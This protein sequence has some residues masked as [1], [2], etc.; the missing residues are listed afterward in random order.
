[1]NSP[2]P[3]TTPLKL[4]YANIAVITGSQCAILTTDG[5]IL[6]Y[7]LS[8]RNT[9]PNTLT[10]YPVIACH[11]P[12]TAKKLELPHIP[13]FDVLELFAF[14][15]PATFITPTFKGLADYCNISISE[16]IDDAPYTMLEIVQTLLKNLSIIP[17]KDKPLLLSIANAMSRQDQGWAWGSFVIEALGGTYDPALPTNPK[18]DMN[19]FDGMPEWAEEAP[20]PQHSYQPVSGEEARNHLQ[21]LLNRRH[22]SGQASQSRAQQQ[23]Y[24]TRV[25]DTLIA[26]HDE[27]APNLL[28][29]QAGTGIGKTFGYL[30]PAQLWAEKNEGRVTISTYTKNLQRQIEQDLHTLY[31][32]PEE[33][34]RKAITQKGRENYLCLLNLDELIA[35]AATAR[36]PRMIVAAGLMARWA[37]VTKDGDMSGN[38]FPGWLTNLLGKQYTLGLTDRRGEC[39][40]AACA[41]YHRC[42]IE[43]MNR[44]AKRA[45]ILISNHA[46]TMIRA[47]TDHSEAAS[48]FIIFD[49]A[50]HLFHAADS[51]FGANLTGLETADLRRWLIGPEEEGRQARIGTIRGRGLRKRLEGLIGEDS[52]AFNDIGKILLAAKQVLPAPGWR[53]RVFGDNPVG[54]T[55]EFLFHLARH[56]AL[57]SKE[58]QSPYS[59]ECDIHPTNDQLI[60]AATKAKQGFKSLRIPLADLMENLKAM[61]EDQ[62]EDIDQDTLARMESL[63]ASIERRSTTMLAAWMGMMDC[64]ID[65]VR[66]EKMVDWFEIARIE[67]KNFDCGY[68]RR[69]KNPMEPLGEVIRPASQGLVL[70][71]AT[72]KAQSGLGEDGW[73]STFDQLGTP[74]L[75]TLAPETIDLPSP[76]QYGEQSRIFIV[77]DVDKQNGIAVANAYKALFEATN[78]G[79]LGLFTSINRLKQVYQS[80]HESLERRSIPLY[81]QHHDN[82][83]IGTLTDMFREDDNACLL[84][85]DAVRDGIN[86]SGQ[87]LRCMVFDRMPWPRPTILHRE[88][89]KIFGGRQYDEN[90]TRL[91]LKQAY[92]RLIR[93]E[94]DKGVFVILDNAMPTRLSD[95]FPQ[96]VSI[97][98]LSLKDTIRNIKEFL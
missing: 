31:P 12:W 15:H 47:A 57:R 38:S 13:V 69:Y 89:K 27:D 36:D 63:I 35:R 52:P 71:S 78:G 92:G 87:S 56:V 97:E 44:K 5:E 77:T 65:Q 46:L 96:D 29:A 54:A 4:P 1:M 49:E 21:T 34:K 45:K 80:I 73:Q 42:F 41:H 25:A 68:L 72:L 60:E 88:R 90:E 58:P 11:A 82:I 9:L 86:V 95:A 8:D 64:L 26:K 22:H 28:I 39:I 59:I 55:E 7:N 20:P 30:S 75:S 33:Q 94:T 14:C 3:Q 84:G 23:N 40:Y 16:D 61:M 50:H 53:K 24:S 6:S 66:D 83:D 81:A 70:T 19:I 17:D 51:A 48:P 76:F 2:V 93:S 18:K 74:H 32:D 98:R 91:K 37:S 10:R 62:A 79:G 67:G 85:T 43:G